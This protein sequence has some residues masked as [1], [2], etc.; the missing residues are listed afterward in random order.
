MGK[1]TIIIVI[2]CSVFALSGCS[3]VKGTANVAWGVTKVGGKAV[4]ETAKF[5]GKGVKTT[6]NMLTGKTVVPLRRQGNSMFV[7]VRVNRK[8]TTELLVDTGASRT[9]ISIDLAQRL[10]VNFAKS[11]VIMVRV[12]DGRMVEAR[13]VYL[14]KLRIGRAVVRN[15]PVVV[16]VQEQDKGYD[17]LLGMTFLN[18]FIF[19]IDSEKGELILRKRND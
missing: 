12:A 6:V 2:C 17:G 18:N 5:A 14:R 7:S 1:K 10:G 15:I 3:L 9:Q 16:L 8:I 19:Q 13:Q 4:W 11:E